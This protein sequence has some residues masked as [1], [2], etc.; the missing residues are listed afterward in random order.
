[1]PSGMDEYAF[2]LDQ[3]RILAQQDLADWW[4]NIDGGA[5]GADGYAA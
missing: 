4:A 3:L 1:M 5:A 2:A